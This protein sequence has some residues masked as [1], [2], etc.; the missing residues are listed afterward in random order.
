MW[1]DWCLVGLDNLNPKPKLRVIYRIRYRT[2]WGGSCWGGSDV[3]RGVWSTNET[4]K[5]RTQTSQNNSFNNWVFVRQTTAQLMFDYLRTQTSQN[6]SWKCVLTDLRSGTI[7]PGHK[8]KNSAFWTLRV[9]TESLGYAISHI[10]HTPF[11]RSYRCVSVSSGEAHKLQSSISN[12]ITLFS[13]SK[14]N[15]LSN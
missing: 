5:L 13:E 3:I 11:I 10:Q 15:G 14:T 7:C 12:S 8:S 9:A 6:N 4:R 1:F 2:N